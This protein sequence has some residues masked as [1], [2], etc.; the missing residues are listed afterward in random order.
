MKTLALQHSRII[1]IGCVAMATIITLISL[2]VE[3]I[4]NPSEPLRLEVPLLEIRDGVCDRAYH[5]YF[6]I[7]NNSPDV[8]R[9]VGAFG[10]C[11]SDGC[12]DVDEG[13]LPLTIQPSNVRTV[14][15]CYQAKAAGIRAKELPLFTDHP[16]QRTLRCKIVARV[17]ESKAEAVERLQQSESEPAVS[18]HRVIPHTFPLV[19]VSSQDHARL[20]DDMKPCEGS[21]LDVALCLHL[22]R[23][24][25]DM[26]WSAESVERNVLVTGHMLEWMLYLPGGFFPVRT[27]SSAAES[28]CTSSF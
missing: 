26:G 19:V 15:V 1:G 22:C 7:R 6:T 5:V 14:S 21:T 11:G 18:P 27:P 23:G 25:F 13:Q 24:P 17:R 4:L 9:I 10:T 28:G 8:V 12:I 2:A 16:V 3:S 20:F